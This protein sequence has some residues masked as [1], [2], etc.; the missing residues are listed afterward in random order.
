M[1]DLKKKKFFKFK[2]QQVKLGDYVLIL[3]GNYKF[4]YGKVISVLK[5]CQ[6]VV[7]EGINLKIKIN[8][9]TKK[10]EQYFS[11]IHLSNVKK[12]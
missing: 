2:K 11:P 12:L 7:V 3:C 5:K 10:K 9:S 8:K 4:K 6:Q 1:K